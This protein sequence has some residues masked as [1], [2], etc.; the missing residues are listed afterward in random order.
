MTT[1]IQTTSLMVINSF[2]ER[3]HSI[4]KD[5]RFMALNDLVQFMKTAKD[6]VLFA[7]VDEALEDSEDARRS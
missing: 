6:V 2:L 4:D 1:P 7:S 5:F 3:I